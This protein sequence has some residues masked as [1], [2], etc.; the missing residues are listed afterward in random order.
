M[1]FFLSGLLLINAQVFPQVKTNQSLI[2]P[3]K[4]TKMK[5]ESSEFKEYILLVHLP[6]NYGP[7]QAQE[8]R[9]QWG[10][11]L[12]QW[13][14]NGTYVTSFVYPNDGY[15]VKGPQKVL[16][17]EG[18]VSD[19]FR[20]VS[21]LILR[22]A[23]Y[24]AALELAKNCPVIEQGGIIEVREIQPRVTTIEY[25]G[26]STLAKNKA[27]IRNLYEGILNTGKL[28]LL[29]E[30]I[31][32]DYTGA[33]GEKGPEGFAET[34]GSIR[35]AF[36]DIKWTVEDLMAEG[37]QVIVR[38]SWMGTNTSSFRGLPASGKVVTDSAIAIYQ[39]S[40]DKISKAW[41]ESDKLGFLQQIG[42]VSPDV[43]APKTRK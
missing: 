41:I 34:V 17:K 12:D 16:T 37:N 36:P 3:K 26:N 20:L 30:L 22:A 18:I 23:S 24:E 38:W 8:V 27:R 29:K 9:E 11:L 35:S 31:S 4:E 1:R 6:L 19:N 13:K 10:R 7:E 25:A 42:L 2:Q 43:T 15:L 33:R 39:F 21:N 5:N 28:D 32:E 14:A 40:G